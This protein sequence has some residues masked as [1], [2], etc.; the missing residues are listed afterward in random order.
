MIYNLSRKKII[1]HHT[2][3]ADSM[4]KRLRGMILRSF[5][6]FD[7]MVFMNCNAVHTFFM[8]I[9]IDIIFMDK[10][11]KVVKCADSPMASCR[12]FKSCLCH[13]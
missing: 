10:H 2:V 6:D 7:A 1:S 9:P 8:S 11:N 4:P 12:Q 3:I 5:S 13:N